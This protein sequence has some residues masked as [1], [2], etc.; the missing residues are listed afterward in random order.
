VYNGEAIL[1]PIIA[2]V[3]RGSFIAPCAQLQHARN[4][5]IDNYEFAQIIT[6]GGDKWMVFPWFLKEPADRN[7]YGRQDGT[8]TYGWAVRYEGP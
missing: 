7:H 4:L 8:G 3:G 1:I 6:L 5:R 2:F